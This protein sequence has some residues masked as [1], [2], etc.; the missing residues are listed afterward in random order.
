MRKLLIGFILIL[1]SLSTVF[2][3]AIAVAVTPPTIQVSVE[4]L[5][6]DGLKDIKFTAMKEGLGFPGVQINVSIGIS[7]GLTLFAGETDNN[8]S[9]LFFDVPGGT[10]EWVASDGVPSSDQIV[11][12][13]SEFCMTESEAVAWQTIAMNWIGESQDA[14]RALFEKMSKFVGF[15]PTGNPF[16][17]LIGST[18]LEYSQRTYQWLDNLQSYIV[19]LDRPELNLLNKMIFPFKAVSAGFFDDGANGVDFSRIANVTL[20]LVLNSTEQIVTY[21]FAGLHLDGNIAG[22]LH[23]ILR[24][25]VKSGLD[26]TLAF[27]AEM[28]IAAFQHSYEPRFL[29]PSTLW[30]SS[31]NSTDES[32]PARCISILN[33]TASAI[34]EALDYLGHARTAVGFLKLLF[35]AGPVADVLGGLVVAVQM[36]YGVVVTI[37]TVFHWWETY[38]T[39]GLF[40]SNILQGNPVLLTEVAM[41][42]FNVLLVVYGAYYL[43]ALLTSIVLGAVYT[44]IGILLGIIGWVLWWWYQQVVYNQEIDVLEGDLGSSLTALFRVRQSLRDMNFTSFRQTAGVYQRSADVLSRFATLAHERSSSSGLEQ[45]F[46]DSASLL[47]AHAEQEAELANAV[48]NATVSLDNLLHDYLSWNEESGQI[49]AYLDGYNVTT[50]KYSHSGETFTNNAVVGTWNGTAY[51]Y[52]KKHVTADNLDGS[53]SFA[54][55]GDISQEWVYRL[56]GGH[57]KWTGWAWDYLPQEK[58]SRGSSIAVFYNIGDANPVRYDEYDGNHN[59]NASYAHATTA[60][61]FYQY[62]FQFEQHPEQNILTEW[63]KHMNQAG[64]QFRSDYRRLQYAIDAP[65]FEENATDKP[66]SGNSW[67]SVSDPSSISGQVMMASVGSANGGCLFGPY[68]NSTLS[69]ENM[70]GMPY[71]AS[72]RLKVSRNV[73]ASVVAVVD[74]SYDGGDVLQSMQVRARDFLSPDKW[75]DFKLPFTAPKTK[76]AEL[77]FRVRNSNNGIANLLFD[78]VSI[79]R[80]DNISTLYH[81]AAYNKLYVP[82]SPWSVVN[83]DS[84]VSGKVMMARSSSQSN[85]W[86]FGPYINQSFDGNSLFGKACIATFRLKVESNQYASPVARID[87]AYDANLVL[88]WTQINAN[89]FASSDTWQNFRLTFVVPIPAPKES[90]YGLEFRVQNLNKGITDLFVDTIDVTPWGNSS[91]IITEGAINKLRLQSDTTWQNVSDSSSFSGLVMKADTSA[92]N[93]NWLFG[94]YAM[95][96]SNGESMLGKPYVVNFRSKVSSNLSP[97]TVAYF[98]VAFNGGTILQSLTITARDFSASDVWQNFQLTF[99]VPNSLEFGLEFRVQNWNNHITDFL[100]DTITV[101]QG[102]SSSD[103]YVEAAHNKPQTGSWQLSPLHFLYFNSSWS[104]VLD[105]SSASG[106]VM[107]ASMSSPRSDCLFGPYITSDWNGQSMLGKPYTATFRLKV[108]SNTA[109]SDVV[110]VDVAYNAGQVLQSMVI[111]GNDFASSYAWH[112][113]KLNFIVPRFLTYGLEF[114]IINLNSGVADVYVDKTSVEQGWAADTAYLE[115]AYNKYQSGNSWLNITDSSSSSGLVMKAPITSPNG[116]CLFGPYTSVGW[117]QES[118]LGRAYV[119]T[120]RLKVSSNLAANDVFSIDVACN[121]GTV[122]QSI[123]IKATDFVSSN[124]WQDFKLTFVVPSSLTYGLEF[125]ITNLNHGTTDI[126]ADYISI[127]QT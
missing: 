83:V 19:G 22:S 24:M 92:Q 126:F 120:F 8:G 123:R 14:G 103:V 109:E 84:S 105:T 50:V 73:S 48:G 78:K 95:S 114:R 113:F 6:G 82:A 91:V 15:D 65:V 51:V 115:S 29:N 86:V 26:M 106:L 110:Y 3:Y 42:I 76:G 119:A 47:K 60:E 107:E 94:P 52:D 16:S 43:Y 7:S 96:G 100:I 71:C 88:Q 93:G 70:S 17:V 40:I 69:G 111:K 4:D 27:P 56:G 2:N 55:R 87:V 79:T 11:I 37:M 13:T 77:E 74:V 38:P 97:N 58:D 62:K 90:V 124:A 57:A 85:G 68:I 127:N 54:S 34:P 81:E 20:Q 18:L 32:F 72:F 59:L 101:V 36:F 98:D 30:D 44:G 9:C 61:T 104:R 116:D 108:S 41:V 39:M 67:S 12:P 31:I 102:W 122:L 121:A 53:L 125:R 1:L 80:A 75:Q 23:E 28:I 33:M 35:A 46:A 64:G 117:N 112:D 66:Q 10:Y 25:P 99:V 45:F 118:M 21:A 89:D 49:R 5:N 63:M